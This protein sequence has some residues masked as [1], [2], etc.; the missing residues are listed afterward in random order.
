MAK[1]ST[2]KN[3]DFNSVI[4]YCEKMITDIENDDYDYDVLNESSCEEIKEIVLKAIY[5]KSIFDWINSRI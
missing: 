2:I 4:E 1:P 3:P 5:G